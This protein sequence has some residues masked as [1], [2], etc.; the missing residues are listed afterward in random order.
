MPGIS[1]GNN[2]EFWNKLLQELDE[3]LQLGLLDKLR[4][5][6]GY[7]LESGTLWI[8][9]GSSVDEEYL[10]RPSVT[11]QLL[12]FSESVDSS[13]GSVKIGRPNL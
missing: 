8:D 13:I 1:R 12:L 10:K 11:Q 7:H 9:P 3:K 6:S 2:P 4:R 5:A